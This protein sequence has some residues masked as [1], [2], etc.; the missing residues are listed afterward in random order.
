[1][2]SN[3]LRSVFAEIFLSNTVSVQSANKSINL[4]GNSRVLKRWAA[5]RPAGYFT[6]G[7]ASGYIETQQTVFLGVNALPLRI[8]GNFTFTENGQ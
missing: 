7:K 5:N 2:S 3:T 1:V 8:M 6:V 4:T